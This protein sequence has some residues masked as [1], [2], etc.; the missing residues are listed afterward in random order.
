MLTRKTRDNFSQ[1]V[2]ENTKQVSGVST[3]N[4]GPDGGYHTN[5][6]IYDLR[7]PRLGHTVMLDSLN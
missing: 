5:R 7:T 6:G 2:G 3:A 4:T 1:V